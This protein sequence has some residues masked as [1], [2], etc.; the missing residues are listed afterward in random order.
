MDCK[1]KF[2]T[3]ENYPNNYIMI[4]KG[5][6]TRCNCGRGVQNEIHNGANGQWTGPFDTYQASHL[7]ATGI[8]NQLPLHNAAI[9]N[10]GWCKPN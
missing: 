4:H 6:C 9:N 5:E 8:S 7:H 10:C 1:G 2:Y 3:Y